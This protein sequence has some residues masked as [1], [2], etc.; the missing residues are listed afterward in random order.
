MILLRFFSNNK[1]M[2]SRITDKLDSKGIRD[3]DVSDRISRDSISVTMDLNNFRIYIPRSFEYSQYTIDDAIRAMIPYCR[4]TT[5]LDRNM[6]VMTLSSKLTENNL[7][8]L[9]KHII[10]ED[11][12]CTL[13]Q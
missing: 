5:V 3:Y 7:V 2:V 1:F 8:D 4:T 9:V 6:Y 10:E 11:E 13:L 12:F